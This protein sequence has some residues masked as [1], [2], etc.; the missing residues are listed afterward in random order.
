MIKIHTNLMDLSVDLSAW[1]LATDNMINQK[2]CGI[3]TQSQGQGACKS[4]GYDTP[5][6]SLDVEVPYHFL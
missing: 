2:S 5:Q 1:L 3:I 4:T 6:L